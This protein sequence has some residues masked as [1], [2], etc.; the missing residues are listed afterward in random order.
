MPNSPNDDTYLDSDISGPFGPG[1]EDAQPVMKTHKY[2]DG[3]VMLGIT[4]FGRYSDIIISKD[5]A[6]RLAHW[7]IAP[8]DSGGQG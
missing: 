2:S 3:S 7:L 8:Y 5:E 4:R 1:V 6:K